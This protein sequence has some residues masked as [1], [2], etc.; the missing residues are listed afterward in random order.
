M[1]VS[2]E[3][4]LGYRFRVQQLGAERA[5]SLLDVSILDLGVQD[6]GPGG[7]SWALANRG[8]APTELDDVS[9]QL[10][11][12]WTLRGAPHFYRRREIDEVA[13][14][15]APYSEADAGKR[16]FDAAKPLREAGIS[17]LEA[18]GVV[19]AIMREIVET[20]TS[21]RDLSTELT[22]R[23]PAP[24]LREC[25]PCQATHS[26]EQ[27]FRLAALQA[28]LELQPGTSPPVLQCIEG[29][30]GP[31]EHAP[32]SLDVVRAYLRLLG[33]A[34]PKT[35]AGY[36][37]APVKEIKAHWPDD[38][39]EVEVDGEPRWVLGEDRADLE[40]ADADGAG[41]L[42]LSP[43][44]LFLQ[45]RDRELLVPD[46]DRRKEVWVVL[47][48]PGAIVRGGEIL[49]TWRPRAAGGKLTLQ[50]DPWTQVPDDALAEQAERFAAHRG[51]TLA[52]LERASG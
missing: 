24:Y 25:R 4:V 42:L 1:A 45:A 32:A 2:R 7:A 11:L 37:D 35:V 33:P 39:D 20:P 38:A 5:R 36:V 52:G 22:A 43:F 49:G 21:K 23:L 13:T 12:A 50:V 27:T 47:G 31:A 14:A 19:A 6:S 28:G 51:L 44:D 15:T 8:V 26:Y 34:T 9:K 48:R 30:T 16:I 18:L 3:Q 41:L 29:W 17:P 40:S 46:P 10:V